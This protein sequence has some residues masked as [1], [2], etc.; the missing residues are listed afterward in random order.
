[1]CLYFFKIVTWNSPTC[2]RADHPV[3]G[4]L[5]HGSFHEVNISISIQNSKFEFRKSKTNNLLNCRPVFGIK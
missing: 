2:Q 3:R 1:M 4:R 5:P